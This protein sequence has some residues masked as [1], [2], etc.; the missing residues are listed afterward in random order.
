MQARRQSDGQVITLS[1]ELERGGEGRVLLAD[2][3]PGFLA[4]LYESPDAVPLRKLAIML[5]NPPEDP[6]PGLGI[7]RSRKW[8]SRS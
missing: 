1:S 7:V 6:R 3:M 8:G 2:G 4:K 5:K